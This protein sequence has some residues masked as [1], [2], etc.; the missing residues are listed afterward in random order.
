MTHFGN[1][2][3]TD[4]SLVLDFCKR[5]GSVSSLT[6]LPGTNYAHIEFSDTAASIE[7][8]K[9]IKSEAEAKQ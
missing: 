3:E 6:V 8:A 9:S 7:L 5:F 1:G 4:Q 2:D